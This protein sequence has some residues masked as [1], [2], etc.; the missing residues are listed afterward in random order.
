MSII[1]MVK[2]RVIITGHSRTN[3]DQRRE[4]LGATGVTLL[5]VVILVVEVFLTANWGSVLPPRTFF[6]RVAV[7]FM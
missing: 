3:N 4:G 1:T 2:S 5:E 6:V 7:G